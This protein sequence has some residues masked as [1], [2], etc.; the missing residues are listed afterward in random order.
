[1]AL[2][3]VGRV[4]RTFVRG[5]VI[6]IGEGGSVIRGLFKAARV[7]VNN[8]KEVNKHNLRQWLIVYK[9][10]GPL[11]L[12]NSLISSSDYSVGLSL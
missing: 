7:G 2:A 11:L 4:F 1:M 9:L 5:S 6:F 12:I 10:K 8:I 3:S